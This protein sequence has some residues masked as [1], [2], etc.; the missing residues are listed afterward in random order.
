MKL[1]NYYNAVIEIMILLEK[2]SKIVKKSDYFKQCNY[3][4]TTL[5]E[6]IRI[7]NL[8]KLQTRVWRKNEKEVSL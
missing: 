6:E 8:E 7:K 2:N 5:K 1:I 4:L 3:F